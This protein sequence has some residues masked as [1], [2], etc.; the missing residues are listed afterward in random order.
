MEHVKALTQFARTLGFPRAEITHNAHG[1]IMSI[2]TQTAW[3]GRDATTAKGRIVQYSH[4]RTF[5]GKMQI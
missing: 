1:Y 5:D 2:E 4:R 3:L